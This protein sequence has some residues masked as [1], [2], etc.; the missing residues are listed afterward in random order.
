M[1][2]G[3]P[4]PT[5]ML[6]RTLICALLLASPMLAA[7]WFPIE[8]DAPTYPALASQARIEGVVV[9]RLTLGASGKVLRAAPL[10]GDP[11]LARAARDNA[12]TWRF[13]QPCPGAPSP[14][15][16][17]FT[18]QFRLDGETLAKPETRFHYGQ[19]YRATVTSQAAHW[20]PSQK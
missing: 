17:E 1:T 9:L 16:I 4:E 13:T 3:R 11:V 2:A 12:A 14:E 8:F 19:P 18:Y 10:S 20:M 15:T 7:D 5:A 6:T